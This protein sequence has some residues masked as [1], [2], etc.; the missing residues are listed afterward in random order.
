MRHGIFSIVGLLVAKPLFTFS[1]ADM[2]YDPDEP[3]PVPNVPSNI[4]TKVAAAA[5]LQ[6]GCAHKT[7]FRCVFCAHAL[8]PF[9]L[10]LFLLCSQVKEYCEHH[11]DDPI[12]DE[13][14]TTSQQNDK[15]DLEGFDAEFVRDIDQGT[16]FQLILVGRSSSRQQ[17]P[18]LRSG[19]TT[20]CLSPLSGPLAWPSLA[21]PPHFP[22]KA[23]N[24]LD[25]KNLLDLTCTQAANMIRNKTTEEIRHTFNIKNDFTREEEEQVRRL[26]AGVPRSSASLPSQL[27]YFFFQV[28]KENEWCEDD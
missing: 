10:L 14:E 27:P 6:L 2:P 3:I 15:T 12:P 4:L 24:F 13:E 11:R 21:R 25:I 16:L 17:R 18:Q 26:M 5:E 1:V 19:C 20:A 9:C 7:E 22:T 8:T 23:A 28:R